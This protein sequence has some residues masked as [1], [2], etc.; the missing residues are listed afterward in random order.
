MLF[1]DVLEKAKGAKTYYDIPEYTQLPSSTAS[2]LHNFIKRYLR[3]QYGEWS[4]AFTAINSSKGIKL[5]Q[6][7]LPHFLLIS[8]I[9]GR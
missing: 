6:H 1:N 3:H 4:L 8:I 5:N 2:I 9:S 7:I